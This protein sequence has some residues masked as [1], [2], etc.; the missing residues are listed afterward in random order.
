MLTLEG[1]KGDGKPSSVKWEEN[2]RKPQNMRD[3]LKGKSTQRTETETAALIYAHSTRSEQ[4]PN[5]QVEKVKALG[6]DLGLVFKFMRLGFGYFI[7]TTTCPAQRRSAL[8]HRNTGFS[9]NNAEGR[10]GSWCAKH[11]KYTN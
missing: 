11:H 6:S 4:N 2:G 3:S 9:L 7:I 10:S 5:T 8:K 1:W